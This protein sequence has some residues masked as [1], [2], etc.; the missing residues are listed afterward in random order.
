MKHTRLLTLILLLL[1][2]TACIQV[3]ESVTEDLQNAQQGQGQN[4][5]QGPGQ[6]NGMM[7]GPP[8]MEQ[9][10]SNQE[11][12][13]AMRNNFG[14][15]MNIY[16]ENDRIDISQGVPPYGGQQFHQRDSQGNHFRLPPRPSGQFQGTC[17][18]QGSVGVAV[19]GTPIQGSICEN[20]QQ[21]DFQMDLGHQVSNDPMS[22]LGVLAD[23]TPVYG[24]ADPRGLDRNGGHFGRTRDFPNGV[25][26]IHLR[27]D[28]STCANHN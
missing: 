4:Q 16:E 27:T 25:Y 26:H 2:S 28:G 23:G 24:P 13:D 10:P 8:M 18:Q 17:N 12:G 11:F 21:L 20:N 15:R 19:D 9:G 22:M 6:G 3:P 7:M 14:D 1:S 5:G